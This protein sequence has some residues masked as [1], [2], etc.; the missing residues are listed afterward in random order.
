MESS[1]CCCVKLRGLTSYC[2]CLVR[3]VGEKTSKPHH[4]S[5]KVRSAAVQS[6]PA[7]KP[8]QESCVE[9]WF[10][11]SWYG[12]GRK[13]LRAVMKPNL[14]LAIPSLE[15]VAAEDFDE[16]VLLSWLSA[17]AH[18]SPRQVRRTS[19][20]LLF[21]QVCV[22]L[23]RAND[24][25]DD[26]ALTKS[27]KPD[28]A[29]RARASCEFLLICVAVP[30]GCFGGNQYPASLSACCLRGRACRSVGELRDKLSDLGIHVRVA[31]AP[32]N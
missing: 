28:L 21:R 22:R 5:L 2:A 32:I 11:L 13:S 15:L 31:E 6:E 1:P 12:A 26:S 19:S 9:C 23:E 30:S 25:V 27:I 16:Q 14:V 10:L 29:R 17:F 24:L 20:R 8:D 4:L 7:A 18:S 3:A